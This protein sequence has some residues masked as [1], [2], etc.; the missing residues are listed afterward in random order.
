MSYFDINVNIKLMKYEQTV[1]IQLSET[2]PPPPPRALPMQR[3]LEYTGKLVIAS[4]L[5]FLR[6]HRKLPSDCSS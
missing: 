2:P 1:W 4:N 5:A 3:H 6:Q